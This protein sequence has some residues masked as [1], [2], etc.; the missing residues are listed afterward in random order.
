MSV[1]LIPAGPLLWTLSFRLYTKQTNPAHAIYHPALIK[2]LFLYASILFC[3]PFPFFEIRMFFFSN[4]GAFLY[5]YICIYMY[6]SS[7]PPHR[8]ESIKSYPAEAPCRPLSGVG[9]ALPSRL[10]VPFCTT[11]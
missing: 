1:T 2:A 8:H 6:I 4:L 9:N 7:S 10:E 3:F 11:K 5:I